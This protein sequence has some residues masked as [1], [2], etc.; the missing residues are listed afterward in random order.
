MDIKIVNCEL[1]GIGFKKNSVSNICSLKC[2]I[3]QGTV[4]DDKTGCWIWT[5]LKA[6]EYGKIR[7]ASKTISAHRASYMEF[8][9]EVTPGLLVCHECDNKLCVNPHH[10]F[11]GTH[12]DNSLDAVAKG[13]VNIKGIKNRFAKFTDRQIEEMRI[14]KKEGFSYKRLSKIFNCSVVYLVYVVNL[15][16]R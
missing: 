13:R 5:R 10:L 14:L 2:R 3:L 7:W 11:L 8:R 9:G 16:R 4:I 6:G 12:K 15:K 1:C